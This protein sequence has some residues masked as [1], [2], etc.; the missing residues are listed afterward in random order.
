[1]D[2]SGLDW[3]GRAVVIQTH[4]R[5]PDKGALDGQAEEA[6]ARSIDSK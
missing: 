5:N 6:T 3:N 4:P 2:F 1:M